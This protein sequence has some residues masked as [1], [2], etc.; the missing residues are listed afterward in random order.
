MLGKIAEEVRAT[1]PED[2]APPDIP[3]QVSKWERYWP[4]REWM[5]GIIRRKVGR[6][7]NPRLDWREYTTHTMIWRCRD[8][9]EGEYAV[10][11]YT[12]IL[13]QEPTESDVEDDDIVIVSGSVRLPVDYYYY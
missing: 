1:F 6:P 8:R 11:S 3:V 9:G 5:D 13:I 12:D 2:E 4:L 7:Q 10:D